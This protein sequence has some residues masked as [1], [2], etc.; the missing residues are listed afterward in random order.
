MGSTNVNVTRDEQGNV[1]AHWVGTV[2]FDPGVY[3]DHDSYHALINECVENFKTELQAEIY[4]N[5]TT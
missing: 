5:F 2:T 4:K 1:V 3:G